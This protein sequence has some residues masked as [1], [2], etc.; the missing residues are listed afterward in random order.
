MADD[1]LQRLSVI[2]CGIC[3]FPPEYCEFGGKF[4]KCKTWLSTNHPDL[5]DQLYSDD[6]VL[7][8]STQGQLSLE[9]QEKVEREIQKLQEKEARAAEK[10]L[11]K[12][13]SSKVV[14]KRVERSKR[15]HVI[16]VSGVDVFGIDAKKLAKTF[17]SKFATGASVTK[18][19]EGKDEIVIQGDVGDEVEHY[20][21]TLLEEKGLD[22]IKV[23]RT[24]DKP[25]KK[26]SSN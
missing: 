14:V 2:Y 1:G 15:K 22:G 26:S 10:E 5:F 24:E 12:K 19:V 11:A 9:K 23:E 17:A 25:K 18:N 7:A 16:A 4:Q 21:T 13:L 20:L 8:K 6:A 3:S